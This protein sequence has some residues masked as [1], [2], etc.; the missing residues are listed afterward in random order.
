VSPWAARTVVARHSIAVMENNPDGILEKQEA[1]HVWRML[2]CLGK[3]AVN[4]NIRTHRISTMKKIAGKWVYFFTFQTYV[5]VKKNIV[6]SGLR[7][8]CLS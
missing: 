4:L 5:V 8:W 7:W 2:D 1:Y 3:Q 6:L